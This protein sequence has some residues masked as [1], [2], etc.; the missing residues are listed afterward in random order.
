L[1]VGSGSARLLPDEEAAAL[2]GTGVHIQTLGPGKD[3]AEV[4]R[5]LY[6]GAARAST[7][8]APRSH[9]FPTPSGTQGIG[10]SRCGTDYWRAGGA[11][12]LRSVAGG[13][14]TAQP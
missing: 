1:H 10:A 4:S 13:R 9:P 12:P 6:A 8:L 2:A 14:T 7:R 3:L 5:R 11:G